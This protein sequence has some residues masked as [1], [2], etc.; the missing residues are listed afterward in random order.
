[1][2]KLKQ[3]LENQLNAFIAKMPEKGNNSAS[4]MQKRVQFVL[5][6]KDEFNQTLNKIKDDFL[7]EKKLNE[8]Q[9]KELISL[10][11]NYSERY[12]KIFSIH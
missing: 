11:K 6:N 12:L 4:G 10:L 8:T 5:D 1:M 7:L 3:E 2:D 9:E